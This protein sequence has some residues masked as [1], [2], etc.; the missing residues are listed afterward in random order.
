[1]FNQ[2]LS[3]EERM[4]NLKDF[5]VHMF[6]IKREEVDTRKEERTDLLK[7]FPFNGKRFDLTTDKGTKKF[8]Q[9]H[10]DHEFPMLKEKP[11]KQPRELVNKFTRW[12]ESGES[13][14]TVYI[15]EN[16]KGVL[17]NIYKHMNVE[18]DSNHYDYSPTGLWFRDQAEIKVKGERIFVTQRAMLDC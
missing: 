15:F 10:V 11:R 17:K 8:I 18:G 1:M 4:D 5:A 14:T 12:D 6:K 3:A 16:K 7:K 9:A 13:N 2:R